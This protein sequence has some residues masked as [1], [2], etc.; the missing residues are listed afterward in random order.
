MANKD[1]LTGYLLFF[2]FLG[3]LVFVMYDIFKTEGM[4]ITSWLLPSIVICIIFMNNYG[5]FS[6]WLKGKGFMY[7]SGIKA[8]VVSGPHPIDNNR[9][10]YYVSVYGQY[11]SEEVKER[12]L[13]AFWWF[14]TLMSGRI[15]IP[16]VDIKENFHEIPAQNCD[17]PKGCI[18][19]HGSPNRLQVWDENTQLMQDLDK[20]RHE[21]DVLKTIVRHINIEIETMSQAQKKDL[22]NA[23][24]NL[25]SIM[26]NIDRPVIIAG[27]AQPGGS[28]IM[29]LNNTGGQ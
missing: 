8:T 29:D 17:D 26:S 4:K 14:Y 24:Q 21:R 13:G 12:N 3:L 22:A 5:V 9:V 15:V 19:Y 18:I 23:A 10:K 16:V 7:K 1:N 6:L 11:L 2:M 27:G 28:S 20:I 25:K